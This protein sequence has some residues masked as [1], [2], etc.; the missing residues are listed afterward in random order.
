MTYDQ[1]KPSI[2]ACLLFRLFIQFRFNI[3]GLLDFFLELLVLLVEGDETGS[4]T[5]V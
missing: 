3:T 4:N 5:E 2:N 1:E